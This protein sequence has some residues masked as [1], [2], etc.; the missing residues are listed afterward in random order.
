M[1]RILEHVN[2]SF[3]DNGCNWV[4]LC[5]GAGKCVLFFFGAAIKLHEAA[6]RCVVMRLPVK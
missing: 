2:I 3:N 1:K 5:I 4:Q 6:K